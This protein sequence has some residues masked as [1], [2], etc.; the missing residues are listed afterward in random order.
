GGDAGVGGDAR[1]GEHGHAAIP[2]QLD[3]VVHDR[4]AP[5]STS[6]CQSGGMH[7]IPVSSASDHRLD[8]YRSLTDVALRR[9]QEPAGGLYMAESAKVI[10]RAVQA[11]HRPRSVLTQEKWLDAVAEA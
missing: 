4:H 8:D 3:R 7:V 1:A 5:K 2:K 6:T 9:V 10:T 11:G